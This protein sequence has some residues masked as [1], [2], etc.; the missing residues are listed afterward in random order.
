MAG[1]GLAGKNHNGGHG[2][3]NDFC[4]FMLLTDKMLYA[5]VHKVVFGSL[6]LLSSP[7]GLASQKFQLAS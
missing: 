7:S 2:L 4:V 6:K 3:A 1:N 5:S